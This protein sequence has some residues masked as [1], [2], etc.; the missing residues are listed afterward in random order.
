[1]DRFRGLSRQRV[2]RLIR[3]ECVGSASQRREWHPPRRTADRSGSS[4]RC[5][6]R[7]RAAWQR[8]RALQGIR[9]LMR[10][11]EHDDG[12]ARRDWVLRGL[13]R[14]RGQ[15][16][17]GISGLAKKRASLHRACS[18]GITLR[19]SFATSAAI[20]RV[21]SVQTEQRSRI[22]R[23]R[24]AEVPSESEADQHRTRRRRQ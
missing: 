2:T 24:V 13:R 16:S 9:L 5:P 19:G 20:R 14:T 23:G 4:A 6:R 21:G 1:M 15:R 8:L 10:T 18:A 3:G 11:R 22:A 17:N 7:R 12:D